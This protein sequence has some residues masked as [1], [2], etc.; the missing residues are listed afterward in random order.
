MVPPLFYDLPLHYIREKTCFFFLIVH[1]V[2][3]QSFVS[4]ANPL[5]IVFSLMLDGFKNWRR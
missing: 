5:L 2:K 1:P 3:N 4:G